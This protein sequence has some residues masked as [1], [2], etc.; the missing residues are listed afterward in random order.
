[1]RKRFS[2]LSL[3]QARRKEQKSSEASTKSPQNETHSLDKISESEESL[4]LNEQEVEKFFNRVEDET[5][6]E[7]KEAQQVLIS[8]AADEVPD[9]LAYDFLQY[10]IPKS[11]RRTLSKW[12]NTFPWDQ[13]VRQA[14][15]IVFNHKELKKGQ[16]E[17]INAVRSG[18]DVLAIM[19]PRSGM[20]TAFAIC[21]V[22]SDGV[23][24]AVVPSREA[25]LK[26]VNE[27]GR[28][29]VQALLIGDAKEIAEARKKIFSKEFSISVVYVLPEMLGTEFIDFLFDFGSAKVISHLAVFEAHRASQLSS[30]YLESYG[31][32]GSIKELFPAVR[33][34]A[35]TSAVQAAH[36]IQ[37]QLKLP[38][39]LIIQGDFYKENIFYEVKKERNRLYDI[40]KFIKSKRDSSSGVVICGRDK[41]CENIAELFKTVHG[42]SCEYYHDS[43]NE[44][45]KQLIKERWI[46][47]KFK[48][49]ITTNA[50][51]YK[52]N[53]SFVI[54]H[55]LPKSMEAYIEDCYAIV[56]HDQILHSILSV[57]YTHLTLPTICS[58]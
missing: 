56:N 20:K 33:V 13:E 8:K 48:V 49:I 40:T 24:F 43:M 54:H 52:P 16:V 58:V 51:I 6:E 34:I 18:G 7:A 57:S 11:T 17:V 5:S 32:I 37:T 4:D 3:G 46:Q 22:T 28:V 15:S 55:S 41:E 53:I 27:L 29:G 14:N 9:H 2:K 38:S 10:E 39:P 45:Y 25:A 30:K 23:T 31:R 42:I 19:P 26:Q 36:D 12:H 1:M 44:Q 35:F 21:A 50:D 47:N